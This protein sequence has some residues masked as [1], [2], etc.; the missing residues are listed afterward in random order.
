MPSTNH[1][2]TRRIAETKRGKNLSSPFDDLAKEYDVWFDEDGSLFYL[3]ELQA[4]NSSLPAL[5]KPWREMYRKWTLRPGIGKI[6]IRIS[7]QI[8][9]LEMARE[10][11]DNQILRPFGARA[12]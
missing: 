8:K 7:P 11:E 3:V 5:S 1:R 4:S 12:F 9:L 10:R 2:T 6:E